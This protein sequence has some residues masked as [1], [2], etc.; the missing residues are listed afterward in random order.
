MKRSAMT[1]LGSLLLAGM[2]MQVPAAELPAQANTVTAVA[3]QA[4]TLAAVGVALGAPAKSVGKTA[5]PAGAPVV[6]DRAEI[7]VGNEIIT[8]LEIEE[9]LRQ[10][11]ERASKEFRGEELEKRLR[12]AREQ[13]LK[14]LVE[15]KVLLLEAR[16]QKI[17]V[18][19]TQ[20][21]E[22]AK[23]EIDGLRSQFSSEKDFEKQLATEHLTVE[24]LQSQREHLVR[25]QLLQQKL[26][27]SKMQE[28]TTGGDVSDAQLAEYYRKHQDEY[29][30]VAR[31][32]IAQIFVAHPDAGLPAAEFE[33]AERA[34]RA[35]IQEALT[36]LNAG[37]KFD[38]AARKYSEHRA[39]AEKGGEVGWIEQG[40]LGMPEFDK[41]VFGPLKAGETSRI[42]TTG[43]G[44]FVVRVEDRQ[45][46]GAVPLDEVRGRIRQVLMN[47]GSD[48]RYQAWIDSLKQKFKVT[49][50][51]SKS[52]R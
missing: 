35:R 29:K 15:Q 22:R 52:A 49:Y 2:G 43:R 10:L 30:R 47:E 13:H 36:E 11:R 8:T 33:K 6:V 21:S 18:S 51:D 39:T 46:G 14:H 20:V 48:A 23:Q 42:I 34:A 50:A 28:L 1:V 27:Q 24:D 32:K 45:E 26:L 16:D 4:D 3:A 19:D 31:A 9:P 44:F 12:L 7:Q 5:A 17:D 37:G 25:E 40:E 38:A 41:A